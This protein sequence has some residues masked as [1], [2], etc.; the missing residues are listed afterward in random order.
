MAI[1]ILRIKSGYSQKNLAEE[2][3]VSQQSV[4]NWEKGSREPPIDMLKKMAN[5]F[6]CTI[7]ELVKGEDK[8]HNC[9]NME[10]SV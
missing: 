3:G 5:I 10:K 6:N 8:N 2:L 4:S 1:R 7:D 9:K